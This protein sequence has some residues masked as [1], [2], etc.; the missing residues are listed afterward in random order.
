MPPLM[1]REMHRFAVL[2]ADVAAFQPAVEGIP[3]GPAGHGVLSGDVA[4][5]PREQRRRPG[6]P[7][8]GDAF[9]LAADAGG[10]FLVDGHECFP[11]HFRVVVPQVG[12]ALAVAGDAVERQGQGGGDPQSALDEDQGDQPVGGVV[13]PGEAGLVLDLLHDVLG[14]V[15]GQGT[16]GLRRCRVVLGVEHGIRRQRGVPAVPAGVGEERRQLA[17]LLALDVLPGELAVQVGQVAFEEGPVDLGQRGDVPGGEE[18]GQPGDRPD[19]GLRA[20][21]GHPGRQPPAGPSSGQVFQ[22]GLGD[23]PEADLGA[24]PADSQQAQLPGVA[25]ILGVPAGALGQV[26]Q[27]PAGV[28]EQCPV[29][30][31]HRGAVQARVEHRPGLRLPQEPDGAADF[32]GPHPDRLVVTTA[33]QR[34]LQFQLQRRRQPAQVDLLMGRQARPEAREPG[35]PLVHAGQAVAD[36]GALVDAAE[37]SL[38]LRPDGAAGHRALPAPASSG[39]AGRRRA[40]PAVDPGQA[41]LDPV[42]GVTVAQVHGRD[43]VSAAGHP[44]VQQGGLGELRCRRRGELLQRGPSAAAPASFMADAQSPAAGRAAAAA[45]HAGGTPETG[46]AA[47]KASTSA[48]NSGR[49]TAISF[50]SRP[51]GTRY[52]PAS[53]PA[54]TLTGRPP[55]H[56]R[57]S[58]RC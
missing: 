9:L 49:T 50:S 35:Q 43:P 11:F 37:R 22:P 28:A 52:S 34:V 33:L 32:P 47:S 44:A 16:A 27:D 38:R 58:R 48:R 6:R 55:R 12:G 10:E 54:G 53:G 7:P 30:G 41:R 42:P 45:H 5:G 3:V 4:Q 51:P 18:A 25:G 20:L 17:G 29:R 39:Q 21:A 31:G 1:G 14:D 19:A 40:E 24:L 26:F 23:V 2:V 56:R 15:A 8:A 57:R 36:P 13:P 46:S